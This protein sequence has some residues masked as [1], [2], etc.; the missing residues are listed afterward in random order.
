[1]TVNKCLTQCAERG[2]AYAGLEYKFECYCSKRPPPYAK[3]DDGRCNIPCAGKAD[4]SRSCG[5][6]A[7]LSVY[8]K[9]DVVQPKWTRPLVCLVMII[10]NEAHTI[11]DTLQTVKDHIDCWY[12]LDTGSDV[13][14]HT[15]PLPAISIH[16][17][18]SPSLTLPPLS[19]SFCA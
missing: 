1:M 3:V 18:R 7:V 16:P 13:S 12:I 2:F 6:S 11:M 14:T 15:S 4:D 19:L 9:P 17:L 5:G 8:H 10:K